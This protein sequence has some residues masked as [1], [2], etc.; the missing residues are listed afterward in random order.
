LALVPQSAKLQALDGCPGYLLCSKRLKRRCTDR[1]ALVELRRRQ[2]R[3]PLRERL[4]CVLAGGV[5]KLAQPGVRS[6]DLYHLA[7]N[8]FGF[9]FQC[10]DEHSQR[11]DLD[12]FP[13]FLER[14]V[15]ELLRFYSLALGE[16][17]ISNW[18][19]ALFLSADNRLSSSLRL[20]A[21]F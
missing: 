10:A 19:C 7:T 8:R 1:A 20:S 4:L 3:A 14:A 17:F 18:P 13:K 15:A 16:D 5:I 12:A 2:K 9:A 6:R 11:A 21:S